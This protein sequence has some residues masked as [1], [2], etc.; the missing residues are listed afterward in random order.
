MKKIK[1]YIIFLIGL[2][3]IDG[4]AQCTALFPTPVGL[5]GPINCYSGPWILEFEDDFSNG[6]LDSEKWTTLFNWGQAIPRDPSKSELNLY[7]SKNVDFVNT[8]TNSVNSA[9]GVLQLKSKAESNHGYDFSSGMVSSKNASFGYG[10]YEIRCKIPPGKGHFPAF[11]TFGS[12]TPTW[13]EIDFFEFNFESGLDE[14]DIV[15]TNTHYNSISQQN[16]S[17][18]YSC[19]A[20]WSNGTDFS[21]SFNTFTVIY[22]P[23]EVTWYV[24][25]IEIR[26][27]RKYFNVGL[28]PVSCQYLQTLTPYLINKAFPV[29]QPSYLI[30]NSRIGHV[31]AVVPNKFEID[32]VRYWKQA[33]TNSCGKD[34]TVRGVFSG[35]PSVSV[36]NIIFKD[37][38]IL[39]GIASV[40]AREQIR[41]LPNFLAKP[42]ENNYFSAKINPL[43]CNGSSRSS[44]NEGNDGQGYSIIENNVTPDENILLKDDIIFNIYPN[45]N[46][47]QFTLELNNNEEKASVVVYDLMG[48]IVYSK[49]SG[50]NIQKIDISEQAKGIYFVRVSIGEQVFNEKV[51]YQ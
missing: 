15:K 24:N 43:I 50:Q 17:D 1:I 5:G 22:S 3:T 13:Q 26:K 32:Y 23:Y 10:K 46:N 9:S 37:N 2:F 28:N 30:I 29:G 40:V 34:A 27:V 18:K 42:T 47:G 16:N 49:N 11:W 6:V 8:S 7:L 19:G 14:N 38:A 48:K 20:D 33:P 51:I 44:N 35:A 45:P 39:S 25:N 31:N 4:V 21:K 12:N 41:I 36:D